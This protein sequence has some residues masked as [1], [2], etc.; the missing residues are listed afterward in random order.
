MWGAVCAVW[1]Y[2]LLPID[3]L[4]YPSRIDKVEV[5]IEDKVSMLM[6]IAKYAL[7]DQTSQGLGDCDKCSI[8]YDHGMSVGCHDS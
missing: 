3:C 7:R 4:Y 5:E 6:A 8:N 1:I 2:L